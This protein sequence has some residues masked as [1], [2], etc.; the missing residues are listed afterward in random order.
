LTKSLRNLPERSKPSCTGSV[1][2][3][4]GKVDYV[5]QTAMKIS[6]TK[7]ENRVD[8]SSIGLI[9]AAGLQEFQCCCR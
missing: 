2:F 9:I 3:L 5:S 4:K 1:Q 7:M 6:V 8:T